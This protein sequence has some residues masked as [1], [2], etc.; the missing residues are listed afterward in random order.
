[1]LQLQF[2]FLSAVR[3]QFISHKLNGQTQKLLTY[4]IQVDI[5][6]DSQTQANGQSM[7]KSGLSAWIYCPI[8]REV[9][10]QMLI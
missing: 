6:F 8:P 7:E 9:N 1:M 2:P 10:I 5:S 4:L 3:R